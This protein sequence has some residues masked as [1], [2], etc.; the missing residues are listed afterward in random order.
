MAAAETGTGG[1][2]Y[3]SHLVWVRFMEAQQLQ[4][5]P[6]DLHKLLG[7]LQVRSC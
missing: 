2:G 3:S 4:Q 6:G 7:I 1:S 5:P